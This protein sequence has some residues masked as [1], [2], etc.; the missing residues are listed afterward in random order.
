MEILVLS[1]IYYVFGFLSLYDNATIVV[2]ILCSVSLYI[3]FKVLTLN[4]FN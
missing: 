4:L 3:V 2:D 1:I